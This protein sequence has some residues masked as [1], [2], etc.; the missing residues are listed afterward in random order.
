MMSCDGPANSGIWCLSQ[1]EYVSPCGHRFCCTACFKQVPEF[2]TCIRC[3]RTIAIDEWKQTSPLA[4]ATDC[5]SKTLNSLFVLPGA[6]YCATVD[7][8]DSLTSLSGLPIVTKAAE[9]SLKCAT[10]V[11]PTDFVQPS[12]EEPFEE[13]HMP[14]E[15]QERLNDSFSSGYASLSSEFEEDNYEDEFEIIDSPKGQNDPKN[16]EDRD[17]WEEINSLHS[18]V[19]D[20]DDWID[21]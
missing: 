17:T 13:L 12:S 6:A 21:K 8:M 20:T 10:N 4:V 19:D 14:P 3:A 5:V 18:E 2:M 7:A 1:V 11:M 15:Q 9:L 16:L